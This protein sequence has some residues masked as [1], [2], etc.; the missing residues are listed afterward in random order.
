MLKYTINCEFLCP[1]AF[2]K[3]K[4]KKNFDVSKNNDTKNMK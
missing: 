1:N 3:K 4:Q 2:S